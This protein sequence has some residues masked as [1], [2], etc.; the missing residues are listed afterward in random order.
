LDGLPLYIPVNPL[1]FTGKAPLD[2]LL[3][4]LS[5]SELVR[6]Y[7]TLI[8]IKVGGKK[9]AMLQIIESKVLNKN[10]H[11]YYNRSTKNYE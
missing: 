11:M 5:K 9:Q 3:G 2:E 4:I 6:I 7:S 10:L 8:F 1:N